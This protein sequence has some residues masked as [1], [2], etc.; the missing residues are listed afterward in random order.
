MPCPDGEKVGSTKKS[1]MSNDSFFFFSFLGVGVR[2][3]SRCWWWVT[4]AITDDIT[5]P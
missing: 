4:D 3:R 2:V 1:N 5:H